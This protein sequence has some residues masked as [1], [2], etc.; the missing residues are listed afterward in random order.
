M[1]D[2]NAEVVEAL[3][4]VLSR[5]DQLEQKVDALAPFIDRAETLERALSSV[6]RFMATAPALV[7]GAA[8]VASDQWS[9]LEDQ[10]IDVFERAEAGLPILE[11]AT[12]PE[13][14][15]TVGK[16]MDRMESVDFL[17]GSA[18]RLYHDLKESGADIDSLVGRGVEVAIKLGKVAETP[19]FEALITSGALDTPTLDVVSKASTALVETRAQ[20]VEPMGFFGV[21]KVLGDAD[22]QR[23]TGFLFQFAR[24]FGAML[25]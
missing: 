6:E 18:D 7:D 21:L 12:R 8:T 13:T 20:P 14:V 15:A 5:L 9:Q 22:V 10:G 1:S 23:A 11:K 25:R 2:T 19:E 3:H 4:R 24:R 16:L 17:S